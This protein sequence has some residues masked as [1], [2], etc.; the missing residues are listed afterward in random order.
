MFH[1][2]R[3]EKQG[4]YIELSNFA[5]AMELEIVCGRSN[6]MVYFST[7]NVNRP[8]LLLAGFE[9]YFGEARVQVI[10]NAEHFYL[11]KC[12]AEEQKQKLECL[13]SKR[14]PCVIITRDIVPHI[15]AVNQANKYNV[16]LLKSKKLTSVLVNDLANYL[17]EML[18]PRMSVHGVLM[19]VSGL[20]VLLTG[21]TGMGKSETALE[22]IH[23]GH[24]LVADDAV[25]IKR[26][27]NDIIGYPPERIKHFMEIRGMGIIDVR[28]MFGVGSVLKEKHIDLVI[29]FQKWDASSECDR[30][31]LAEETENFFGVEIPKLHMPV[32]VGRNLAIVVEVAARNQRLK[33]MG[34]NAL[35]QLLAN[36]NF[37]NVKD[38]MNKKK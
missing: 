32:M 7:A 17:E 22:L 34:F 15:E 8:G 38:T 21:K 13:F 4:E 16:P 1:E 5:R 27:Q 9:D 14:T 30:L 35:D 24:R 2:E 18:A 33:S 25:I 37:P 19:E 20:G 6:D 36:C 3:E 12:S 23:R 28:S 31:G 29:Q 26:I 10:G 11:E